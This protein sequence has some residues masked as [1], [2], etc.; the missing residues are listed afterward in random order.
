MISEKNLSPDH[1]DV[2]TSLQHFAV[3]YKEQG[4]Y[5]QAETLYKR[6]LAIREK[7][8]GPDHPD[9]AASLNN[10]VTMFSYLGRWEE[11]LVAAQEA[12]DIQRRRAERRPR[13]L[14][15]E[16]AVRVKNMGT[17]VSCIGRWEWTTG[18]TMFVVWQQ[19]RRTSEAFGDP[20]RFDELWRTTRS[21]GDNFLSVKASFWVPVLFGGSQR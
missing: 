14:L 10:L 6:S 4:Q 13:V 9:V 7:A 1:P 19:N 21:A 11:A 8:L 2:A 3:V 17:W 16:L 15:S 5:A 20:A 18:S 12:A